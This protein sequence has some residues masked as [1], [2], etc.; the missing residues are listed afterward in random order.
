MSVWSQVIKNALSRPSGARY[1]RCALQVNPFAYVQRHSKESKARDE[2]EYNREL[3]DALQDQGIEII[4]I[5]DHYRVKS[6]I[7]LAQA[8][9]DRG[10]HV[11]MGFEAVTK[12]GIHT[13]CLFDPEESVSKIDRFIGDCGIHDDVMPSPTG[14]KD[15]DELLIACAEQWNGIAIAAHV[16]SKGGLLNTM[17]G[18]AR[19][20]AWTHKHLHACALPGPV[21]DAPDSQRPILQNR[22]PDYLRDRP[23]AVLNA[24]DI[25][26]PEHASAPG[27][28]CWIKMASVSIEGLRQAFLD[29]ESRIRLTS[30]KEPEEHTELL[31]IAWEGGFL[32][33][34]AI[35]FNENL[36]VLIGG[37]GTGKST[38]VESIRFALDI[39][40]LG[41]EAEKQHKEFV[42]MVLGSGTKVSLLLRSHTPSSREYL[43]ERT[44]GNQP[45]VKDADGNL[46][47]LTPQD[48]ANEV[49]IYGQHEISELAR[50]P[51]RLTGLLDRFIDRSAIDETAQ[52]EIKHRLEDTRGMVVD[53]EKSLT[54]IDEELSLLPG[55]R[56]TLVRYKDMGIDERLKDKKQLV[57][58]E[59]ILNALDKM[60]TEFSEIRDG[61]KPH[62]PLD[63]ARLDDEK[64]GN[65]GGADIL[66]KARPILGQFQADVNSALDIFDKAVTTVRLSL[67]DVRTEWGERQDKVNEAHTKT[68]RE[69]QKE[70]I[71]GNE[72]TDLLKK[73]EQLVPK[74]AE[75]ASLQNKLKEALRRRREAQNDWEDLI[76]AEFRALEKA[77]KRVNRKL[78]NRIEVSVTDKG[79]RSELESHIHSLGGRIADTI[80]A[81]KAKPL[82]SLQALSSTCREG[83]QKLIDLYRLPSAQAE[84]LANA[85]TDFLMQLEELELPA[86]TTIRLNVAR[87][88]AEPKW[89]TLDAL[90]TGQKATAVLLLL[91][92]ESAGP[93]I[94]DQPEDDLDNRFIT[95][96]IVPQIKAEKLNR[97]FIFATHNANIPVLGDAE[98]IAALIPAET[99]GG[100]EVH[101]PDESLGSID[102]KVVRELVEETL[103][104]GKAAFE[105]RRLKYGF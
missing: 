32:D 54:R 30:D 2:D 34:T 65:L 11:F 80:K 77:A 27:A 72:Y 40:P 74:K 7:T 56:E 98:L 81:L 78:S 16:S 73:I 10:L 89:K 61:F 66:R 28:S 37:R 94:V 55:L 92:L 57:T 20:K 79:D 52:T 53:I 64:L 15:I 105:L 36:N 85:G 99:S 17:G 104:G 83:K 91:L 88:G 24:Q 39:R 69:L 96:G 97:Q 58:E 8:A 22:N 49:E 84:K 23:M 26:S 48:I 1:F 9:K 12:D 38:I 82:L 47:E 25:S 76:S 59:A 46:T 103:E 45:S 21:K 14:T 43:V 68:L 101:L 18:Q 3:I 62:L 35:R 67:Q 4:S 51:E 93:L 71:D 50:S 13:L 31:A 75:Q 90:S 44:V 19:M 33:G 95:E 60:I 86:T 63:L 100:A 70:G 42:S 87:D 29:P 41:K 5:T 102:S 6:G